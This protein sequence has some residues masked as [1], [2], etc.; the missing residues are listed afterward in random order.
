MTNTQ[1]EKVRKTIKSATKVMR[2]GSK[3]AK[4]ALKRLVAA[5]IVTT[6]GTFHKDYR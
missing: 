3:E 5:G 2:P 1:I 4:V 6:K